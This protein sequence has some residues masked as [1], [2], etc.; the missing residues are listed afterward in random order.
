MRKLAIAF[1][2]LAMLGSGLLGTMATAHAESIAL[3]EIDPII[4]QPLPIIPIDPALL[5]QRT[6][7]AV[8][9]YRMKGVR[10][11]GDSSLDYFRYTSSETERTYLKANGYIDHGIIG[12]VSK[13][14]LPGTHALR[15]WNYGGRLDLLTISTSDY[16][17]TGYV[18]GG[19][20]GYAVPVMLPTAPAGTQNI[21][22]FRRFVSYP[23]SQLYANHFYSTMTYSPYSGYLSGG[24]QFRL[25]SSA[26]VLQKVTVTPFA[27]SLTGTST[28][29]IKWTATRMDGLV[30]ILYSTD[31]GTNY[32]T[33]ASKIANTGQYNWTVP[34]ASSD[35]C[36]IMVQWRSV[37]HFAPAAWSVG[38]KFT[39]TRNMLFVPFVELQLLP[40]LEFPPAAPSSLVATAGA[41]TPLIKL[42]WED[43][44]PNEDGFLVQR[45]AE[46]GTWT[47]LPATAAS[48]ATL[49]DTTVTSGVLYSYRVKAL[50]AG[51]AADSAFSDVVQAI[52]YSPDT[53]PEDMVPETPTATVEPPTNL[54]ATQMP[55]ANR[56]VRLTWAASASTVTGYAIERRT[57]TTWEEIARLMAPAVLTYTDTGVADES[58]TDVAYRAI[59]I[60]ELA[61][62]AP[63]DPVL[64]TLTPVTTPD[65]TPTAK[66]IRLRIGNTGYS[67]NGTNG[68]LDAAPTIMNGRTMLPIRAIVEGLGGTIAWDPGERRVTAVLGSNEVA[69]WID[70]P[71]GRVNSVYMAIDPENSLVMPVIVPPGRT[72][73]PV[74]FITEKL[75]CSVGWNEELR[76][77]TITYPA[78]T[79]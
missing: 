68:M 12:Y 19:I 43:N 51:S 42:T 18:P 73:L 40:L 65:P 79:P 37:S 53:P 2:V 50:G 17:S 11:V 76:E 59:A 54:V 61:D 16:S 6:I 28:V 46:G 72:L 49:D 21:S 34:N 32:S 27:T 58:I 33:I 14:Y 29:Q 55:G 23:L 10:P 56:P 15:R 31:G 20:L 67:V 69:V 47:D 39:I 26:A 74:R 7:T 25:W 60:G 3:F 38:A 44:S 9:V 41:A 71:L 36:H 13:A 8:P 4:I 64:L 22:W 77:V 24:Y 62:S 70:N 75:G 5:N 48:V 35:N 78:V 45:M 52:Y 1:L 57:A 30:D 66:V 63:T